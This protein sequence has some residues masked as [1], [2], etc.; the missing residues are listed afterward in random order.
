M[1]ES[2]D[3]P[4]SRAMAQA[5][6]LAQKFE[7]ATA[8]NPP[9]G[10][11]ALD[12][13]GM[14]LALE[15]HERAGQGHAEARLLA[16]CEKLGVLSQVTSLV[17][18]LEPCNHHGRTPPCT[19]AILRHPSIRRVV[20]GESDPNTQVLGGG[21]AH[22]TSAGIQVLQLSTAGTRELIATFRHRCQ[23]GRPWVTVKVALSP[24]GSMIPPSG[25]KT[26][27]QESSLVLAHQ[28]RR[29]ADAIVTGSGT[30][31]SDF[32]LFTVRKVP[33]HP[34]K[35]RI[36]VVLDRRGRTPL[37]WIRSRERDGFEVWIRQ[38]YTKTLE[39]LG[40]SEAIEVLV[41]AGPTLTGWVLGDR[42]NYQKCVEIQAIE[43]SPDR[44]RVL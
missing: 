17:V 38:D 4:E 19:Q 2:T 9:V 27:T 3:T 37:D 21:A 23:T 42:K 11:A 40:I 8:P 24:Q 7:G 14:I 22:L 6:A 10:A 43:G 20:Y 28:L 25:Q 5:V 15:A 39:E 31:L 16:T 12:A 18:T 41:E 34:Y 29:R 32:P 36:L 30:V 1:P 35:K 33:D 44:I 26:F 13:H